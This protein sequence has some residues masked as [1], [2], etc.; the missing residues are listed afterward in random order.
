M[1]RPSRRASKGAR[2]RRS[3]RPAAAPP[4]RRKGWRGRGPRRRPRCRCDARAT[5][6]R[7]S[8][9][10]PGRCRHGAGWAGIAVAAGYYDQA[11]LI[12]EF[13]AI[14]GVTP[15][16]VGGGDAGG[17]GDRVTLPSKPSLAAGSALSDLGGTSAPRCCPSIMKA[18]EIWL[19]VL[20]AVLIVGGDSIWHAASARPAPPTAAVIQF[21]SPIPRVT[22]EHPPVVSDQGGSAGPFPLIDWV[23]FVAEA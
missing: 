11:H 19:P 14:A 13:R 20:A 15:T 16:G 5:G 23:P 3:S 21:E 6:H 8:R 9:R 7:A 2:R 18:V 1:R 22:V 17:G 10:R 12:A 4:R